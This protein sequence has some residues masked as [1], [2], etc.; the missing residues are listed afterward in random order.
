[1]LTGRNV[2]V[3]QAFEFGLIDRMCGKDELLEKAILLA[4]K[5]K[6]RRRRKRPI[7]Q[8]L[9]EM[10]P[11]TRNLIFQKAREKTLEQTKG[12]YPAP[13]KIIDCVEAGFRR[14]VKKGAQMEIRLF[15]ELVRTP[16]ARQLIQL[17]FSMTELK[18]N[19]LEEHAKKV[20]K[21]GII[22]AGKMGSGIGVVSALRGFSLA[23]QDVEDA[24]IL[25][26]RKSIREALDKRVGR[27]AISG[28]EADEIFSRIKTGFGTDLFEDVDMVIETAQENLELK[29]Q[30][31]VETEEV[32]PEGAIYATGTSG[33][34]IKDIARASQR[35]EQVI[36]LNYFYPVQDMMLLEI[37]T[38]PQTPDWVIATAT[39][40][41]IAQGKICIVVKD[42]PGFFTNRILAAMFRE[43][44][45]L[46]KEGADIVKIDYVLEKFGFSYG[47]VALMDRIGFEVLHY[48]NKGRVEELFE[49]RGYE[50]T[51]FMARMVEKGYLGKKNGKGFYQYDES[52]G[53]KVKGE[54][55]KD[56]YEFFGG[57]KRRAFSSI[58]IQHRIALSMVNEAAHCL[59][60]GIIRSPRDGDIGAIFGPG[61]PPFLGG[62]FRFADSMGMSKM[63]HML[64]E[65]EEDYGRRFA[66]APIFHELA[67]Q[68]LKFY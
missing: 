37:V 14:G 45:T 67:E 40:M 64:R 11:A 6:I 10:I 20:K 19:H 42:G 51:N 38:T 1:M 26:I 22:G 50:Q 32:I 49:S 4:E 12:N 47:P 43:T 36:G 41:G 48:G 13:E 18:K 17:F 27:K 56:I 39:E 16:V 65:L 66:P 5:G 68:G 9:I 54:V 63:I 35:P 46:L 24:P 7:S 34:S 31:L 8:Q 2:Y 52:S 28:Y 25:D 53:R 59:G 62:P 3:H 55:N 58:R 60:E 23:I 15:D 61:F 21:I 57:R 44:M 29:Q 30:L 33:I